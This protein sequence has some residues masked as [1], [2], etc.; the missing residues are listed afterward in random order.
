MDKRT[1]F[2]GWVRETG[3][4]KMGIL[5]IGRSK[6]MKREPYLRYEAYLTDVR[7]GI[8]IG[9]QD[10]YGV[11]PGR[12]PVA[13]RGKTPENARRNLARKIRGKYIRTDM[14]DVPQETYS[15]P[16]DLVA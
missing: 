12:W 8:S 15:V 11:G 16:D 6:K 4:L 13:A 2:A 9:I 1:R 5:R 3:T 7:A 10:A 14:Q